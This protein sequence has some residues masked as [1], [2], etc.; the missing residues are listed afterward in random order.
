[1]LEEVKFKKF[2]FNFVILKK[3]KEMEDDEKFDISIHYKSIDKEK[4]VIRI[5]VRK[6]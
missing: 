3:Q 5:K 2:K 6:V 4:K 1:M